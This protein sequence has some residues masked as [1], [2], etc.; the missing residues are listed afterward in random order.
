V[1]AIQLET[2]SFQDHHFAHLF[3]GCLWCVHRPNLFLSTVDEIG[4]EI[5]V[6]TFLWVGLEVESAFYPKESLDSS[7]LFAGYH[8]ASIGKRR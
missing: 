4:G 6:E 2:V 7:G 1:V 8:P 5:A 3:T